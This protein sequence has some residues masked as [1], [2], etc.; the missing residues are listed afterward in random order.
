MLA[1][2]D[3]LELGEKKSAFLQARTSLEVARRNYEREQRLFEQQISSEKEYLEAKGE[4][5]R[6]EAAYQAA[7]EALRLLGIADAEL[8]RIAWG[9][10]RPNLSR[11]SRSWL[12]SSAR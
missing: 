10:A 2:L 4:F 1:H 11:T 3:S 9:G 6:S 5:E 12:R 7:R 8:E